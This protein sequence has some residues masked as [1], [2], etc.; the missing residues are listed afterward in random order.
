MRRYGLLTFVPNAL[1]LARI[2]LGLVFP[3]VPDPWRIWVVALAAA[4]DAGDGLTARWLCVESDTG[5]LLD[6]IADKAFVLLLAST[7][8]ADGSIDPLWAVGIGTRD[9]VVL[10]GAALVA[11]RRDWAAFRRM[12][13]TWL[14]KCV[15]VGQFAVL[16][17][18][19]V[20]GSAPLWLLGATTI[21]SIG[22]AIGYFVGFV[23]GAS[24][25][26]VRR[27]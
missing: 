2:A 5:R 18:A 14:G 15:T 20:R 6:P 1:S 11:L 7:L 21:L 8:L 25:T 17:A 23:Q 22:S 26:H 3:F 4:T 10:T 16:L 12:R 19:V 27:P 9:I 24:R 13:P